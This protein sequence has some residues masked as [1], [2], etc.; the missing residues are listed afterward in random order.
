METTPERYMRENNLTKKRLAEV[1]GVSVYTINKIIKNERSV[2]SENVFK[3]ASQT[4]ISSD[5]LANFEITDEE[6]LKLTDRIRRR[7]ERKEK[8]LLNQQKEAKK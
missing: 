4:N 1:C 3:V 6:Y 2:N 7:I 5:E 8:R